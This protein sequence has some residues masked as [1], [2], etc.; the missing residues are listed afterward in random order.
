MEPVILETLVAALRALEPYLSTEAEMLDAASLNEGRASG[1]D[2]ASL[3]ARAALSL[4]EGKLMEPVV[5]AII[6]KL[7]ERSKE[8]MKKSVAVEL[9]EGFHRCSTDD[10]Y[11]R[12]G[13]DALF[14]FAAELERETNGTRS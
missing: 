13:A 12:G 14:E 9:A 6:Q 2:V 3:K 5:D 4:A 11:F 7:R 10:D 8:L 1:F